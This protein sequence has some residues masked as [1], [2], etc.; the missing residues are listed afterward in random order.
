MTLTGPHACHD[1]FTTE[2]ERELFLRQQ[3][4][5]TQSVRDF[6]SFLDEGIDYMSRYYRHFV[7]H[8]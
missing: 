4:P 7:S 5:S 8:P 2:A 6:I 1:R 3:L